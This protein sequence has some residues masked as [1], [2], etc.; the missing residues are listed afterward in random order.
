V[1]TIGTNATTTVIRAKFGSQPTSIT[2]GTEI[3][4]GFGNSSTLTPVNLASGQTYYASAWSHNANGYSLLYASAHVGGGNSM[5][6]IAI[7][8]IML[9]L[10][11]IAFIKNN[12]LLHFVGMI[13]WLI[14]GY[15]LYNQTYAG[16]T[17][18]NTAVFMLA[19]AMVLVHL[20]MFI[21]RIWQRRRIAD[22][23]QNYDQEKDSLR[24]HITKIGK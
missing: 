24:E 10:S 21:G 14:G 5:G 20:A 23:P 11:A 13:A 1:W 7:I 22:A 18:I 8:V 17:Y 2:D 19:I 3:Y 4:N 16:N 12:E 9:G 15:V 6:S